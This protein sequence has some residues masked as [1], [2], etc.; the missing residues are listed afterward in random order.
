MFR[1]YARRDYARRDEEQVI[2]N[3]R[4]SLPY[5]PMVSS[6][7]TVDFKYKIQNARKGIECR[8]M[9]HHKFQKHIAFTNYL[10][11][12]F[13]TTHSVEFHLNQE[14]SISILQ[15]FHIISKFNSL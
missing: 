10:F 6:I 14:L 7:T 8:L 11:Q 9:K 15:I 3:F 5:A 4:Q 13:T 12:Y 1:N 2:F